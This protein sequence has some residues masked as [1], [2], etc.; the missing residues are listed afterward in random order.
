[1][2]H[3]FND[4]ILTNVNRIVPPYSWVGHLPFAFWLIDELRP[5]TFVELGVHT[6]NSYFAFCQ[7]IEKV[8]CQ[9]KCHAIDTWAGDDHAGFY[10]DEIF[11]DVSAYNDANYKIFSRLNRSTFDKAL[12]DFSDSSIDLL[13][14]DGLHTYEAVKHDF[15]TWLPKMSSRGV[16]IFHDTCVKTSDFGVWKLWSELKQK[17][18]SLEFDHSHGLGVLIVGDKVPNSIIDLLSRPA[19]ELAV[20]KKLFNVIGTGLLNELLKIEAIH[21]RE[22][23]SVAIQERDVAMRER[24]AAI[25]DRNVLVSEQ[26]LLQADI[27]QMRN[28]LSWKVT[29]PF[30]FLANIVK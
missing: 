15:E 29:G 18:T 9:T 20:F 30:R 27:S 17:Y 25:N 13:H 21:Y 5:T 23:Y 19:D 28:T 3:N 26:D 22:Q 10:S 12:D 11:N 4:I 7:A 16:I 2:K 8:G 1:M 14:I 6:G 24:D